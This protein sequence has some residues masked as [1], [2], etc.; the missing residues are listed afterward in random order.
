MDLGTL[1]F[2]LPPALD[3][4]FVWQNDCCLATDKLCRGMEDVAFILCDQLNLDV[5][6]SSGCFNFY[7]PYA[8]IFIGALRWHKMV[9][10]F[11]TFVRSSIPHDSYDNPTWKS[12][13]DGVSC[14][15]ASCMTGNK[16]E[17]CLW[18]LPSIVTWFF[19]SWCHSDTIHCKS[20]WQ[21]WTPC[22]AVHH[23]PWWWW[24]FMINN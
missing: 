7:D 9:R 22:R 11:M 21:T 18:W 10:W 1:L 14:I 5:H 19:S 12:S 24:C 6:C 17:R 2:M 16:P 4:P 3:L 13:H 15:R 8:E 23:S 20:A